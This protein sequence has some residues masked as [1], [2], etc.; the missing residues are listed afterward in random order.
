MHI[1]SASFATAAQYNRP[2][3]THLYA[4]GPPLLMHTFAIWLSCIYT[5]ILL[6]KRTCFVKSVAGTYPFLHRWKREGSSTTLLP[7][8][9]H[10]MGLHKDSGSLQMQV[11][12]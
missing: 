1:K 3:G 4:N 11:M 2:R 10:H 6:K 9:E 5:I 8:V 7:D 12:E